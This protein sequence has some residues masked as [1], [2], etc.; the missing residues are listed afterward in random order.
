[1]HRANT[2]KSAPY[3][4]DFAISASGTPAFRQMAGGGG[5]VLISL[6]VSNSD[7]KAKCLPALRLHEFRIA[8]RKAVFTF[9]LMHIIAEVLNPALA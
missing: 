8:V 2:L 7:K 9:S 4:C 3:L 1:V 6:P 5:R